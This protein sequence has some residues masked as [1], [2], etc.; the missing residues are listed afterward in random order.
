MPL[1][2]VRLRMNPKSNQRTNSDG[3]DNWFNVLTPLTLEVQWS[4]H[5]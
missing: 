3:F 5:L 4:R 2:M 1:Y